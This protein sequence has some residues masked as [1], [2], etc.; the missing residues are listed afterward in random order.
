MHFCCNKLVD[1]SILGKAK[2]CKDKVQKKDSTS[3]QCSS[4]QE[5][6]CCSNKAFVKEGNDTLKKANVSLDNENFVFLNIFYYSYVSLFQGPEENIIS[7]RDYRPPLLAKDIQILN[8]T[9]L[10]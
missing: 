8:E 3:K 7:F 5:K 9:F 10:I 2:V 1:I 4:I 6:D